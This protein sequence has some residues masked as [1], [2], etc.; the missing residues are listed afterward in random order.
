[1][2]IESTLDIKSNKKD[3]SKIKPTRL[4][5]NKQNNAKINK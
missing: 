4:A 1:M 2:A 5:D 3:S